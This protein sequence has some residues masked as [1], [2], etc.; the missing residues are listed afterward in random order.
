M[1]QS[2]VNGTLQAQMESLHE[3]IHRIAETMITTYNT[4]KLIDQKTGVIGKALIQQKV[5]AEKLFANQ[6]AI[7]KYVT[8]CKDYGDTRRNELNEAILD[9]M[10]CIQQLK[11]LENREDTL[12]SS[13]GKLSANQAGFMKSNMA[14]TK[15]AE[16]DLNTIKNAVNDIKKA[17]MNM[18]VIDQ[19]TFMN[20]KTEQIQKALESYINTRTRAAAAMES[21]TKK[22]EER[23][24]E[25]RQ[26]MEKQWE[27]V[28]SVVKTSASCEEKTMAMC[29]KLETLL[30]QKATNVPAM[31]S[32]SLEEMFAPPAQKEAKPVKP[33]MERPT[34]DIQKMDTNLFSTVMGST[35]RIS[36]EDTVEPMEDLLE[37]SDPI[38][39]ESVAGKDF[40]AFKQ[41]FGADEY[42][43]E[44]LEVPE[45]ES[46]EN[47]PDI[48]MVSQ[49]LPALPEDILEQE[50]G[51]NNK[52]GK[53]LLSW[54]IKGGKK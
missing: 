20:T 27:A 21:H 45:P 43:E 13:L 5:T 4:G 12:L 3:E 37:T 14:F 10:N 28:N 26:A 22:T 25:M 50:D 39:E 41:M 6:A 47:D 51:M 11:S 52:R 29:E 32:L 2:A 48:R 9:V 33:K 8:E 16:D 36:F 49:A 17:T 31:D 24:E 15:T 42:I 44:E 30:A 19:V 7:E 46:L 18:N 40:D 1:N 53:G 23:I 35:G 38:V 34:G 54:L